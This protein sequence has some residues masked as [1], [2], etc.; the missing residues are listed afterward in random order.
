MH[1]T[2]S[3]R[4]PQSNGLV[5]A[6]VKVVKKALKKGDD[7][8]LSLMSY[9]ST[10]LQNGYSPAELLF[11]RR[12]RTRLPIVH[13]LL[14]PKTVDHF[15]LHKRESQSKEDQKRN[16]DKRH[17][18]RHL[19]DLSEGQRV[20]VTDLQVPGFVEKKAGAPRSYYV[21]TNNGKIRRNRVHLIPLKSKDFDHGLTEGQDDNIRYFNEVEPQ[22]P[23]PEMAPP[24]VEVV[25][26]A[27]FPKAGLISRSGRPIRRPVRF[28]SY[29][30]S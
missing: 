27:T 21:C 14:K 20:W 30:S 3:P 10:P 29:E 16:Y 5:E 1:T 18:A 6:G 11:G 25:P 7:G 2:S 24:N 19:K 4:Y 8:Y 23:E 13:E 12:L 26:K 17:R 28:D 22:P 15:L 9:R